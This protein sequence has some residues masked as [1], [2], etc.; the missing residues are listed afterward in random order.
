MLLLTLR[1]NDTTVRIY[2][3]HPLPP[4]TLEYVNV[5]ND[6]YTALLARLEHETNPVIIA[7]DFNA[8]QHA[9]WMKQLSEAGFKSAHREVGRGWAVTFPNGTSRFPPI[10]LD[11]ILYT[12]PIVCLDI[13]EGQG[14][15]SDHKPLIADFLIPSAGKSPT[16]FESSR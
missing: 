5:W 10:R 13:N 11:H 2:N 3:W 12:A 4:R 6:Q 8:T 15:G 16:D 1:M 9:Y 14:A 7:G